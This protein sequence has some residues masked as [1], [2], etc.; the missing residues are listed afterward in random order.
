L[1]KVIQADAK[2]CAEVGQEN[3]NDSECDH[4]KLIV[5]NLDILEHLIVIQRSIIPIPVVSLIIG[6]FLV[7]IRSLFLFMIVLLS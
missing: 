1:R 2:A 7:I 5:A 6:P 3:K 4:I